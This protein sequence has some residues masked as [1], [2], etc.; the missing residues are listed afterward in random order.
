MSMTEGLKAGQLGSEVYIYAH[1]L[2]ACSACAPL[3][4]TPEEI[5]AAVNAGN[6]TGISSPWRVSGEP[7]F[8]QGQPNP[9][10]CDQEP[11]VRRHWLMEC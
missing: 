9:A 8:A 4:M 11:D 7:E 1:G 10:P 5:A 6:P 2:V 3:A